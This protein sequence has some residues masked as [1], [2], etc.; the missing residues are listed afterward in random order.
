MHQAVRGPK[1][2]GRVE[3]GTNLK[4]EVANDRIVRQMAGA[5]CQYAGTLS[6]PEDVVGELV[7]VRT[8]AFDAAG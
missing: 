1:S 8:A 6:T 3:L 7:N 5:M 4:A 2:A